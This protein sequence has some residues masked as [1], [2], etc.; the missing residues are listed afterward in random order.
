MIDYKEEVFNLK[1][2]LFREHS[3]KNYQELKNNEN[4]N[5]VELKKLELAKLKKLFI[6]VKKYVPYYKNKFKDIEVS[7]IKLLKDWEKLPILTRQDVIDNFK[8]LIAV[9]IPKKRLC[10][11]ETGGM[12]DG[13]PLKA[14]HDKSYPYET[15][16]QRVLS[17]W[18]VKP[19]DNM[20]FIYRRT[21]KTIGASG[22][23]R[24]TACLCMFDPINARFASSCSRNGMSAAVAP[25]TIIG[26]TSIR[27]TFSASFS[28]IF[29][30][31]L[32]SIKSST[33]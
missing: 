6:Y 28:P 1:N 3:I 13:I 16:Q 5:I 26:N 19:M 15:L 14:Y 20:A 2:S 18:G 7:D 33:I 4:L 17:W 30:F 12:T 31:N 24:G 23:S 11:I 8:D 10:M 32:V 9:D 22:L 27:S 25:L 21:P 29:P